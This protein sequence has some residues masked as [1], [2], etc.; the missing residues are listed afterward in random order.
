MC[1]G[2]YDESEK[3]SVFMFPTDADKRRLWTSKIPRENFKPSSQSVVCAKHFSEQFIVRCDSVTRPDGS[4]LTVERSRPKLTEDAYP[5]I[6]PNCPSYLS[7]E[8][9]AKRTKPDDRR[10]EIQQ[11]DDQAFSD[12]MEADKITDFSHFSAMFKDKVADKLGIW[13]YRLHSRPTTTNTD[14][15]STEQYWSFYRIADFPATTKP[16]L[17]S[18]VRVFSDLHVEIFTDT[19]GKY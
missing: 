12:W 11:R 13:M 9:P 15:E 19:L 3:I 10:A 17:M 14:G 4:V 8:P 2:N 1:R 5:S 16:T 18:A 6:F 7:E